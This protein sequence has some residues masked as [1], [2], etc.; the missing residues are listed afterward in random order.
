MMAWLTGTATPLILMLIGAPTD[1]KMSDAFF[2]AMIW[3]SRFIADMPHPPKPVGASLIPSQ[4]F[5]QACLRAGLRVDFFDNYC[6]VEAVFAVR[7]RQVSR[8]YN[9]ASR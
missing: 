2:S 7:G 6:T 4:Q 5:V 9:G 8:N 1:R 3:N